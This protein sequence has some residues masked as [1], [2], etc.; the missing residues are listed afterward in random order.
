MT[1][2]TQD[3]AIDAYRI[4]SFEPNQGDKIRVPPRQQVDGGQ[5]MQL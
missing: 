3:I 1:P 2:A 4:Q 5:A